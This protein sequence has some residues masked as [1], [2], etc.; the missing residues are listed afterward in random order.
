MC[1]ALSIDWCSGPGC[2]VVA[3]P[4]SYLE[5]SNLRPLHMP[6]SQARARARP[7]KSGEGTPTE[8]REEGGVCQV[9]CLLI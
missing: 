2:M 9:F 5:N 8:V 6:S 3:K 7:R 4:Q 1:C